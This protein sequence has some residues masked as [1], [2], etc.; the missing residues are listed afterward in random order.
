MVLSIAVCP[1]VKRRSQDLSHQRYYRVELSA[2]RRHLTRVENIKLTLF[3][4]EIE[5]GKSMTLFSAVGAILAGCIVG[6]LVSCLLRLDSSRIL[7]FSMLSGVAYVA[8]IWLFPVLSEVWRQR[9]AM[10][11]G[12][13]SSIWIAIPG[14]LPYLAVLALILFVAIDLLRFMPGDDF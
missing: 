13:D 6:S 14:I 9:L 4:E 2:L 1:E 8:A 10:T 3:L 5:W 12:F 11:N 7:C